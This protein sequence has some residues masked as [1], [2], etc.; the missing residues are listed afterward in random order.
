MS[1]MNP[2]DKKLLIVDDD[3]GFIDLVVEYFRATGYD[4]RASSNLEGAISSFR[5]HKPKVVLLDFNMPMVTGEKF[6]PIL[7]GMDPGVRV[8]VVTGCLEEE[9]Q[10]KFRDLKYFSFFQKGG[11]SLEKIR[12]KVDEAFSL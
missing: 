10:H 6:L 4:V 11:L 9:V 7:Q 5:Q 12:Q 2:S 8:I 1:P 3:Q